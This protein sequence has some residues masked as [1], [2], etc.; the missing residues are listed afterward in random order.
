MSAS[1]PRWAEAVLFAQTATFTALVLQKLLFAL[2]FRSHTR[3]IVSAESF[4]N[5]LLLWAIGAGAVLQLAVVYIPGAGAI[6][7]T[8]PLGL[9]EWAIMLP[10]MIVPVLVIDVWK[11]IA[12]R[13]D[14]ASAL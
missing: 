9:T 3:S 13:R 12:G 6:F 8:V 2:T 1:D 5:P 10:A 11:V 7:R 4:K 14:P